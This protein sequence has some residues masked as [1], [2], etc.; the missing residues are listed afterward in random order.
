MFIRYFTNLSLPAARVEEVL[1]RAPAEWLPGLAQTAEDGGERLL[2]EVGASLL[3]RKV[4]GGV[5]IEVGAPVRFP[6]KTVLPMRWV[7][8]AATGLVPT[9]DADLEVGGLGPAL[10]QL[11]IS[12]RYEPPL[13]P[14]GRV[15]DRALLHRVA[16][17][18][19][20]DFLDRTGAGLLERAAQ[21]A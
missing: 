13:G 8:V 16:E 9:L 20:K 6:S 15:L 21:C 19:V 17:A 10:T 12:A 5:S 2:A 14:A 11:S 18:T 7:A 1:L 3:G 4:T